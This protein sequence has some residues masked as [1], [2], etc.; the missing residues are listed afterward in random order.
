MYQIVNFSDATPAAPAT[1]VNVKWQNDASNPPNVSA[2]SLLPIVNF[3]QAAQSQIVVSATA[4]YITNSNLQMPAAYTKAIGA[5]TTMKWRIALTKTAAG[6]GTFQVI[7]YMGTLGTTGDT[8]EVTQTIGTQDAT[9][10]NMELDVVVT[11]T[12]ATAFYW[13]MVPHQS[14]ATG[15]GFGLVYPAAAAQFTGTVSGLTT[16][17]ASLIFGL[18]VVFTTGT[19]TFVASEVQAEAKGVV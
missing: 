6:T 1:G 17:T 5:G 14:A 13:T 12:S 9:A 2:Y 10:D 8:A 3:A 4:Y 15:T 19:P 18:G 11:F 7:I 16:T